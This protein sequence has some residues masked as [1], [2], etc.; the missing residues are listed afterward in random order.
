MN[1]RIKQLR[2]ALGYTQ[3]EFAD[4]LGI[5]RNTVSQY[6]IGRNKPIDSIINFICKEFNVN[7]DWLING[8]G[9]MFLDSSA[10]SLDEC[11]DINKLNDTERAVI[12]GFMNLEP[13]VRQS[14]YDIFKTTLET[15]NNPE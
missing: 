6:E 11:A 10:L 13:D 5:K 2:Q 7:S 15:E 14:I 8:N 4:H 9:D 3:Q 12:R 1:K